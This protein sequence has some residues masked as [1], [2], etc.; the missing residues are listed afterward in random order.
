MIKLNRGQLFGLDLDRHIALDAGAGTGKTMVMAKRYVQHLLTTDQRST[1]LLSAGPREDIIGK[2]LLIHPQKERT[3]THDWGG[4]LPEETVA[5]TFTRKAATELRARIRKELTQILPP[6]VKSVQE[7]MHFDPRL[8]SEAD[9]EMLL[10]KLD[11]APITTIDAFLSSLISP[12]VGMLSSKPVSELMEDEIV[13]L[14]NKEAIRLTWKV[15]NGTEAFLAG[16]RGDVDK[17]VTSKNRV[18]QFMGGQYR[19]NKLLEAMM[20]NSLFVEES[21]KNLVLPNSDEIIFDQEKI[22]SLFTSLIDDNFE[23][24]FQQLHK[25]FQ[26]WVDVWLDGGGPLV[27]KSP[28]TQGL[29]R[30]QFIQYL[31]THVNPISDF[32]KIQWI[33]YASVASSSTFD[34]SLK[35]DAGFFSNSRLSD[36]QKWAGGL[37][38]KK[39]GK[40]EH[41]NQ[42]IDA[43]Y[44]K[45]ESVIAIIRERLNS[46]IGYLSRNLGNA[47]ALFSPFF[48]LP[49]LPEEQTVIPKVLTTNVFEKPPSSSY[50]FTQEMELSIL[51]DLFIT[52]QG[53]KQILRQIRIQQGLQYHDDRHELAEDLLLTR[54]PNVCRD[55]Y[56]KSII[57]ALDSLAL[58]PW[59]DHH[60]HQAILDAS[61]HPKVQEDLEKRYNI[62]TRIRSKY[63]AYIIDEFQDTNPQHYR[64]L[65]RLWGRRKREPDC[66]KPPAGDWDPTVCIVGDMKQ[67]IYRFRQADV[68]VMKRAVASIREI[69][70]I[71]QNQESRLKG[72]RFEEKS[73]DPRPVGGGVGKYSGFV[74]ADTEDIKFPAEARFHDFRLGEDGNSSSE[75]ETKKR[76]EGHVELS[77]NHRTLPGLLTTL[78]HLFSDIFNSKHHEIT[79]DWHARP[80]PLTPKRKSS[81][82]G[83]LEW[84]MPVSKSLE[85]KPIGLGEAIDAFKHEGADLRDQSLQ[86]MTSRIASLLKGEPTKKWNSE[87]KSYESQVETYRKVKPEEILILAH[88]KTN[89]IKI[90]RALESRGIPAVADREG[91][92]LAKPVVKALVRH[93]RFMAY[94]ED[95]N[96]VL[97]LLRNST[98]GLDDATINQLFSAKLKT[99][100]W[101]NHLDEQIQNQELVNLIL[102]SQQLSSSGYVK[103]ALEIWI[104]HSD[105]FLSHPSTSERK[106]IENFLQLITKII[107]EVGHDASSIYARLNELSA[108]DSAGPTGK[109]SSITGAVK[110]MTIHQSKGL[111]SPVV[112]LFDPFSIGVRDSALASKDHIKITPDLIAAQLNPWPGKTAPLS[113]LWNLCKVMENTQD[114][115]ERRR[116]LYVSLTRV[117]DLLIIVGAP[118]KVTMDDNGSLVIPS[119]AFGIGNHGAMLLQS[120]WTHLHKSEEVTDFVINPSTLDKHDAFMNAQLDGIHFY[121][122]MDCF[123]RHENVPEIKKQIQR[124]GHFSKDEKKPDFP[125]K[126]IKQRIYLATHD[127]HKESN[128]E[129]IHGGPYLDIEPTI[130]GEMFHR[131]I[132]IGLPNPAISPSSLSENWLIANDDGLTSEQIIDEIL[133]EF[134][135]TDRQNITEIKQRLLVLGT[136][137]REGALGTLTNGHL[138]DGMKVIGLRTELPFWYR[139]EMNHQDFF[140][141]L[142]TPKGRKKKS[143]VDYSEA[144][145]EG[146]IDLVLILENEKGDLY[147]Q[148]IDAKTTGAI[149]G[150]NEKQPKQGHPLQQTSG[151]SLD[152]QPI[153][154]AEKRLLESHRLQLILYQKAMEKMTKTISN[155]KNLN[156]KNPAIYSA[157]SGRLLPLSDEAV[158]RGK[159]E[160]DEAIMIHLGRETSK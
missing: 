123:E 91:P 120:L 128:L 54:C 154:D 115:A 78:N 16:A 125:I 92:L 114:R 48:K 153:S 129:F 71:E 96:A 127:L 95:E 5:I 81:L 100:S 105:L 113:G 159:E 53:V 32:E 86:L 139:H 8:R 108:L 39:D 117:K 97:G 152:M 79:G 107:Q 103:E 149:N 66:P 22:E 150:F 24:L 9:L 94:P 61:A 7:D 104:D 57:K 151:K 33:W 90:V 60:I 98:I 65:C 109:P 87:I 6:T 46:P 138:V 1:R 131:L 49:I 145:F 45:A 44:L 141:Y 84:L 59:S 93:L 146:R 23:S 42:I 136:L 51:R 89:I 29:N 34:A 82:R 133:A 88:S 3:S 64:L 62:L 20:R 75:L 147:L 140:R 52:H 47:A 124:I 99:I 158:T 25:L 118:K 70:R 85:P 38:T 30:F 55:W 56:P 43:I 15:Q 106:D 36:A 155:T 13:P 137:A 157:A 80:Q 142:W 77:I 26:D 135:M 17:F 121:H 67:S 126:K 18:F 73:R 12:W 160:L 28:T 83:R 14:L 119:K 102:Y 35:P 11:S 41:D 63:R 50:N 134:S 2:G 111:E 27:V 68:R 132:E 21:R 74:K 10:S 122:H 110:V 4:L 19:A 156:L 101:L 76:S 143:R 112:I 40:A 72:I 148:V 37:K 69:N 144:I 31:L 116:Q 58:N 130:F